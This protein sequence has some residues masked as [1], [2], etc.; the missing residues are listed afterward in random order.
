IADKELRP[1]LSPWVCCGRFW[2]EDGSTHWSAQSSNTSPS[3]IGCAIPSSSCLDPF[4]RSIFLLRSIGGPRWQHT[5]PELR[6]SKQLL[7]QVK[8]WLPKQQ[9][10]TNLFEPPCCGP[11]SCPSS[12]LGSPSFSTFCHK[13]RSSNLDWSLLRSIRSAV[14]PCW[15]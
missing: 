6:S 10:E 8:T 7:L 11:C 1:L 4:L 15:H 5:H 2:Q 13:P 3:S 9:S 12:Q 14:W